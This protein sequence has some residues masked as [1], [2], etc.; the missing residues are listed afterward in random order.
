MNIM[1][2]TLTFGIQGGA[3][4]FNE[5][6]LY[7]YLKEK[8]I[9]INT[10]KIKYLFTSER[11]LSELSKRN[12]DYGQFAMHNSV[13]GI[14]RESVHA[15]ARYRVKVIH[16]FGIKI[17]HHLMRRKDVRTQDLSQI[18]THPQVFAQ[19]RSTLGQKYPHLRQIVGEGD[20]I[21][22]AKAAEAVAR[23]FVPR[24]TAYLGNRILSSIYN[25][26]II[27]KDLQDDKENLTTFLILEK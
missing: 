14:V 19:C 6:A 23:G 17:Q 3:G 7:H 24:S 9:N 2:K 21:D 1:N 8:H 16:E 5:L 27:D 11:V 18:M 20:L 15:L 25:L 10:V 22:N 13:G 26:E 4:S 12:I